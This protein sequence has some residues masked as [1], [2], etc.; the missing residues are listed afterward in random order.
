MEVEKNIGL[1]EQAA[2]WHARM[3]A[4]DCSDEDRRR[5]E[6][7]RKR[8]PFHEEAYRRAAG[9]LSLVEKASKD[10]RFRLL[11]ERAYA[12]SRDDARNWRKRPLWAGAMAAGLAA[13]AVMVMHVTNPSLK[14]QAVVYEAGQEHSTI[15]LEDGSR[16]DLD[17]G[18]SIAVRMSA[19]ARQIDLL[20]GRAL[21]DVAHD[22]TRPF[23]VDAHGS[24]TTALGTRFQ[25]A[26]EGDRVRVVLEEGAVA[27]E[28]LREKAISWSDRLSPGEQIV[29][30]STGERSKNRV[31]TLVAT[32]WAQNRHIFRDTRL[33]E[34]IAEIN[35]Y[36]ATK[37]RIGDPQVADLKV[38]GTFIVGDGEQ[39]MGAL[40]SVLP[41]RMV[42]A[43][44]REILVFRR[45]SGLERSAP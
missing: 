39:I 5:L 35:R 19:R 38:A 40:A 28:Q 10:A 34:A 41:V 30:D 17:V 13:L 32:S 25:V 33:E 18:T 14:S 15:T 36:S 6:E 20:S 1:Y 2:R 8:S 26:R 23:S 31:D 11:A 29:I 12:E 9:T 24:R 42:R 7:W 27:V 16:V 37:V 3:L 4:E 22:S 21:F 44:D 43:G 45:H